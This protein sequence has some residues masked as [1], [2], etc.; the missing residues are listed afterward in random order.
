[1]EDQEDQSEDRVVERPEDMAIVEH[2]YIVARWQ[3]VADNF[4]QIEENFETLHARVKA[5]EDEL[6]QRAKGTGR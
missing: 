3:Q 2:E 6:E 5:V 4:A 1:M